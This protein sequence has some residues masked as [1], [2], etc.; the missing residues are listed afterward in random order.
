MP[1]AVALVVAEAVD[2]DDERGGRVRRDVEQRPCSAGP[3]ARPR[4][5]PSM[6]GERYFVRG[7]TRTPVAIQSRVPG[8]SFSAR[9]RSGSAGA[10]RAG[11]AIR[12]EARPARSCGKAVPAAA[13]VRG[14][15]GMTRSDFFVASGGPGDIPRSSPTAAAGRKARTAAAGPSGSSAAGLGFSFRFTHNGE[16][17]THNGERGRGK[18]KGTGRGRGRGKRKGQRARNES[19][20]LGDRS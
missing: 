9:I 15:L 4:Q 12:A 5:Q 7:S 10:A 11:L 2:V 20:F 1:A 19:G 13:G 8:R 16:R 17:F 18:G 3:D 6:E 14:S